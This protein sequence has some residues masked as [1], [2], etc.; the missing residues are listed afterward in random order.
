MS[1]MK[2]TAIYT[3]LLVLFISNKTIAQAPQDTLNF[4][5]AKWE[6]TKLSKD[7][8]WQHYQFT[9]KS[10]F[11]ANQN[12]HILTSKRKTWFNRRRS[13]VAFVSD[14][15]SLEL[16]SV[17]A[18]NS[19]ALAAIN[20]SFFD[21]KKG[22]AVDFIRIDNKILDTTRHNGK[23]IAEHQMSALVIKNNRISI[24]KARD[25]V[26]FRWETKIDA[27][28]VMV[29]GPL[30]IWNGKRGPLSINAFNDNRHPRSCACVTHKNELILL[31]ADGRTAD[32]QGLNL[33]ELTTL[34][35][36]LNCREAV[37]LDGG[38]STT[39]YLED[40]GVVNMPCDN[41]K[42]DHEGERKVSNILVIKRN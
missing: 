16:T 18:K 9:D 37:N 20:G 42:F 12:I 35:L 14:G 25:S 30:L 21:T 31:T 40:K 26:D 3:I 29:T 32:A 23:R 41:K 24:M 39:L 28:N 1:T 2:N 17:L 19:Q 4:L 13:L 33:H 7:I 22:G 10:L 5:N 11:N 38:G 6:I 27:P 36:S 34:M 15:D 8:T